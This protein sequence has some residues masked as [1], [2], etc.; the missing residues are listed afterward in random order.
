VRN[1]WSVRCTKASI[2]G[3]MVLLVL[4]STITSSDANDRVIKAMDE[5]QEFVSRTH[6]NTLNRGQLNPTLRSNKLMLKFD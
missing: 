4:D 3:P 2:E 6:K 5:L 1:L